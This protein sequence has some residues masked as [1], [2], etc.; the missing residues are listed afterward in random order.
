MFC[1]CILFPFT[2]SGVRAG[3]GTFF[4][5]PGAGCFH[6]FDL[7]LNFLVGGR[8]EGERVV[9]FA[10]G[11]SFSPLLRIRSVGVGADLAGG[12]LGVLL[13]FLLRVSN[14]LLLQLDLHEFQ[15]EL[16]LTNK[17]VPLFKVR[18]QL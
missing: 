4:S 7:F 3:L 13:R 17:L 1:S 18:N 16:V 5:C 9:S 2:L 8:E 14:N 11:D 15:P 10:A 12:G 6:L